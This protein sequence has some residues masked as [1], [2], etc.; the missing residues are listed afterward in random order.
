M[1]IRPQ[2]SIIIPV[3]NA[4]KYLRKCLNSIIK[5]TFKDVEIIC[6]ND[7]STD[8]SLKIL[9][10]YAGKY[11]RVLV[12]DQKNAGSSRARNKGIRAAY[13]EYISFVDSDNWVDTDFYEILHKRAKEK[14][15]D[16]VRAPYKYSYH[17]KED[18]VAI[19]EIYKNK[20]E[21]DL[22]LGVNEH[23]TIA[24]S[25]LYKLN[26]LKDNKIDYFDADLIHAHDTAFTA[27]T[28]FA[29]G[30][31]YSV[32]G[33][34]YYYRQNVSHQLSAFNIARVKSILQ[35]NRLVINCINASDAGKNDY[36]E[37]FHRCIW[38]YDS[39][40]TKA[41]ALK[42]FFRKDSYEYFKEFA[43]S[44]RSCKYPDEYIQKY[45]QNY[46][47]YVLSGDF[48]GYKKLRNIRNL[49]NNKFIFVA[50]DGLFIH[51]TIFNF[52]FKIKRGK[53][54]RK[55]FKTIANFIKSYFLFPW[56]IYKTYKLVSKR[57][58]K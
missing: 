32:S 44:L 13:G 2:I 3:Y 12:I 45:N 6:V 43:S 39:I 53:K 30:K 57:Y 16:I 55:P 47:K 23:S 40:F 21:N 20:H 33:T 4:E 35:C 38:R 14:N 28:T 8:S 10:E 31:M 17:D 18:D 41:A 7:G 51:I 42:G 52:S 26:F 5:Q 9:K 54:G 46:F 27:R 25:A 49:R 11:N 48:E 29:K 56:Y 58:K 15:A 24:C 36:L 1:I 50:K 37:A 34:Y 19:N 22:P